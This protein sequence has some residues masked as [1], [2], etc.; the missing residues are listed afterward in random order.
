MVT[1]APLSVAAS[2]SAAV[3]KNLGYAAAGLVPPT[4]LNLK[5]LPAALSGVPVALLHPAAPPAPVIK[6]GSN[7]VLT[8]SKSETVVRLTEVAPVL[9]TVMIQRTTAPGMFF[10]FEV[11][12][13]GSQIKV[14]VLV[15]VSCAAAGVIEAATA[16]P[17]EGVSVPVQVEG[18][19]MV[20]IE[21]EAATPI[22]PPLYCTLALLTL[23][24]AAEAASGVT[25]MV[26]APLPPTGM[27]PTA[28][29]IVQVSNCPAATVPEA[30]QLAPVKPA[31]KATL[32]Y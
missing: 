22:T 26:S 3:V 13:K 31:P 11:P 19:A 28:V 32:L 12:L 5:P 29:V 1:V 21:A 25:L 23:A 17:N 7:V 8:L 10:W 27:P 30:T 4:M 18:M 20:D 2:A 14:A 16:Q 9:A 15:K 24:T 6:L